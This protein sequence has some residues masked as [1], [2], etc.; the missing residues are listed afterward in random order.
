MNPYSQGMPDELVEGSVAQVPQELPKKGGLTE[1]Q[2]D[3]LEDMLRNLTPERVKVGDAMV[4]CLDHA[5]SAEEVVECIAE[6]LSILQT[7]IPKKIARLFL[8]S[9]I[10]HNCSARVPHA[11][12]YR[13]MFEAKLPEVFKDVH[14]A[15]EQIDARLKAEQFKQKVMACF[16]AWEE[17]AIYASDYLIN[18]QN[19]FL[20]LIATKGSTSDSPTNARDEDADGVPIDDVD[21]VPLEDLD[22]T[23]IDSELAKD[24]MEDDLNG[25]PIKGIVPYGDDIDGEPIVDS[26]TQKTQADSAK[27]LL[28]FAPSK[29]E[30]VDESELEA[31]AITLSKWDL[32][33]QKRK[34][35]EEAE[36]KKEEDIDGCPLDDVDDDD[37][38]DEVSRGSQKVLAD[39]QASQSSFTTATSRSISDDQLDSRVG[40]DDTKQTLQQRLEIIE[41]KRAKLR[42]IEL[43][44]MKYQDELEAGRRSLKPGTTIAEQV[45]YYRKKQLRKED[46]KERDRERDREKEKRREEERERI[47][48]WERAR[49]RERDRGKTRDKGRDTDRLTRDISR[50]ADRGEG[51]KRSEKNRDD[52][53]DSERSERSR[54]VEKLRE[55]ERSDRRGRDKEH[56]DPGSERMRHSEDKDRSF[57]DY[58]RREDS[59]DSDN[60]SSAP[61]GSPLVS[62]PTSPPTSFRDSPSDARHRHS[63]HSSPKKSSR[64]GSPRKSRRSRSRS[65]GHHKHKRT[66]H[67]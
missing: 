59:S 31:Q 37:D 21:G 57:D 29:W 32:L 38:D 1:S 58:E 52:R 24:K 53:R 63:A 8:I 44:V 13:K 36:R 60:S 14:E 66:R 9:D 7:P 61:V 39:W 12:F 4:W 56:R 18:L 6:S 45:E 41:A 11:S 48:E 15:Y 23:P 19:I 46:E 17:W 10:L 5:D 64:S 33:E 40:E 26:D 65:A 20:G 43:K 55:S 54:D 30:T 27:P 25:I 47:K 62:Y 2:R 51:S 3:R 28:T 34:E 50:E 67:S 16:R 49:D 42:E 35:E 22:G